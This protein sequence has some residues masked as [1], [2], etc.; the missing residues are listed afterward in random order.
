MSPGDC[1]EWPCRGRGAHDI[2]LRAYMPHA[3]E[4]GDDW[5]QRPQEKP[6]VSWNGLKCVVVRCPS[7]RDFHTERP[8]LFR[9]TAIL[10]ARSRFAS[11][12]RAWRHSP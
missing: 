12:A 11:T 3:P 1:R 8:R 5:L 4:D 6:R 9:F 10:V 2:S 7:I